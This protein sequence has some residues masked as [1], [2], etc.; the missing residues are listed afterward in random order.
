MKRRSSMEMLSRI[1]VSSATTSPLATI[2]AISQ[3]PGPER[4]LP[5]PVITQNV[6]DQYINE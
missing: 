6:L 1:R 4:V 5:Q 3:V 2:S